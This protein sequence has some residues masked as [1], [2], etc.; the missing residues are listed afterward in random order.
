MKETG[1][2]NSLFWCMTK[3][4]PHP[5]QVTI[6]GLDSSQTNFIWVAH[7]G[8]FTMYSDMLLSAMVHPFH[9]YNT[10]ADSEFASKLMRSA[11]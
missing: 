1:T 2:V 3:A 11:R 6:T 7:V 9:Y 8:H 10:T 4:L 5:W